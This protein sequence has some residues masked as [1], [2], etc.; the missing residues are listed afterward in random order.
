VTGEERTKAVL[1]RF[2]VGPEGDVVPDVDARLP[3]RGLW[4]LARRD[5][6]AAA[7]AKRLFARAARRPVKVDP[8]LTDRV[9][10]LLARRCID[11]LGLARR[12]GQAVTGFEKVRGL[13]ERGRCGLVVVAADA[14]DEGR[15]KLSAGGELPVSDALRDDE[16]G[17]AFAREGATY[18]GVYAGAFAERIAADLDRLAGFRSATAASDEQQSI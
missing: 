10:S 3:G 4:T 8:Q 18:A 13:V 14:S 7:V 1:V 9:E 12:A 6:V 15:R 17:V 11:G 5:I 16:L 2:V